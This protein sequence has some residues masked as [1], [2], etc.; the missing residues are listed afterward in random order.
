MRVELKFV[1]GTNRRAACTSAAP[2]GMGRDAR[3][4]ALIVSTRRVSQASVR[5]RCC[6]PHAKCDFCLCHWCYG[7]GERTPRWCSTTKGVATIPTTKRCGRI[8]WGDRAESELAI[9]DRSRGSSGFSDLT[10]FQLH[11]VARAAANRK[12]RAASGAKRTIAEHDRALMGPLDG[13]RA[14]GGVSILFRCLLA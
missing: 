13:R 6:E 2:S 7:R 12:W 8:D 4:Y 10:R 9:D 3:S 1:A 11:C 5:W 14:M